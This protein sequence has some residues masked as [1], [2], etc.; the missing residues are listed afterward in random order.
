MRQTRITT[1]DVIVRVSK[2][3]SQK[4]ET[5]LRALEDISDQLYEEER[6]VAARRDD[7]ITLEQE[8]HARTQRGFSE[9]RKKG[10]ALTKSRRLIKKTYK[11]RETS[12]NI[13]KMVEEQMQEVQKLLEQR[14]PVKMGERPHPTT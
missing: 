14:A 2:T 5:S 12:N 1:D 3:Y 8:L 10:F 4:S 13:E 6:A 7:V 11:T 9:M